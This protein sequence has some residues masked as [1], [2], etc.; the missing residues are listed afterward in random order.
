MTDISY[1]T[2]GMF[3][4]FYPESTQGESVWREMADKMDGGAAVLNFEAARVIAEIRKAGYKVAKA[5]PVTMSNDEL[6]AELG[7]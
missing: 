3:T 4:R 1:K 7:V 2:D 5:K 6:L